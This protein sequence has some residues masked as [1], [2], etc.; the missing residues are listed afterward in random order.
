[1]SIVDSAIA[2]SLQKFFAHLVFEVD[3]VTLVNS[4]PRQLCTGND[5]G[6]FGLR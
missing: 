2:V 1:M 5:H 3:Y 6:S 4:V